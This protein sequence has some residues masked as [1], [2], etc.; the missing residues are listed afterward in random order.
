MVNYRKNVNA[1]WK[2][3]GGAEVSPWRNED[4]RERW[5]NCFSSMISSNDLSPPSRFLLLRPRPR[6]PL[7]ERRRV[8][9]KE[10]F[11]PKS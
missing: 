2:E 9:R 6:P 8:E 10:I 5:A 7:G 1:P 3:E 4:V 11:S